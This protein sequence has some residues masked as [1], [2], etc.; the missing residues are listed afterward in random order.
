[1]FSTDH[2]WV[3]ESC[4]RV[5]SSHLNLGTYEYDRSNWSNVRI[6]GLYGWRVAFGIAAGLNGPDSERD[7]LGESLEFSGKLHHKYQF[8]NFKHTAWLSRLRPRWEFLAFSRAMPWRSWSGYQ[9]IRTL[10]MRRCGALR[11][12]ISSPSCENR[13]LTSNALIIPN[14]FDGLSFLMP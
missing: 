9:P 8:L 10:P 4:G 1:M 14:Q 7:I 11:D 3:R 5:I 6:F 12:Q 13:K 2:L